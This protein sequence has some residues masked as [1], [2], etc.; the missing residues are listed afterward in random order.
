MKKE[1]DDREA[2]GRL[3]AIL[4]CAV[5]LVAA[6][7][8]VP[9]SRITGGFLK[10]FN[11]LEDI[12]DVKTADAAAEETVDPALSAAQEEGEAGMKALQEAVAVGAEIPDSLLKP[13]QPARRGDLVV[14]EDYSLGGDGLARFRR[15]LAQRAARP[16]RIAV[17]GDSYIEGDIFTKDLRE[18]LQALYGGRG[19]GYVTPHSLVS[20]FR[21]TVR[22]SDSGWEDFDLRADNSPD[23]RWLSGQRFTGKPGATATWRAADSP[24]HV[25]GWNTA[26]ILFKSTG[27]GVIVTDTGSGPQEHRVSP[28]KGVQCI[29]LSGEMSRLTLTNRSVSGLTVSGIW[30]N[31]RTGVTVDNMSLRGN[32]GITHRSL[33]RAFARD[34]ARFV[35]YDLIIVEYGLNALT[36]KQKDYS[37]YGTMMAGVLA[38]LKECYPNADIIV[39]G[40]GDRG[41]KSGAEVHSIPTLPFMVDVQ[42]ETARRA[43]VLFWDTREAMGGTDAIVRWRNDRLVNADYIHLNFRGGEKLAGLFAAALR[44]ALRDTPDA[45]G[46]ST[47]QTHSPKPTADDL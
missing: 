6:L 19:V 23:C 26:T 10:D 12:S 7:S 40:A 11:L 31:D 45:T 24:E 16:V 28:S 39:M 22:Q 35:D 41:R 18:G 36:A 9:W 17:T 43:G 32:S 44:D 2:P 15:A 38:R 34:M 27:S 5:L 29:S 46:T 3:F 47:P 20:G 25:K 8:S 42:R 37:Y 14:L 30:L 33:D 4:A 13:V 1:T 21:S